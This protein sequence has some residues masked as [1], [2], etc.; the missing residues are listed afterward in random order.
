MIPILGIFFKYYG[1]MCSHVEKVVAKAPES[2]IKCSHISLNID[3][4][5]KSVSPLSY[6][7]EEIVSSH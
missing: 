3:L 5:G 7:C 4:A 2:E 1:S 6:E